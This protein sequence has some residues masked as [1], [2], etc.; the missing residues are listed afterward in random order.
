MKNLEL[1]DPQSMESNHLKYSR[2]SSI[3]I[4]AN[5]KAKHVDNDVDRSPT[6]HTN[7][8]HNACRNILH[9]RPILISKDA[10]VKIEEENVLF[11]EKTIEESL[12]GGTRSLIYGKEKIMSFSKEQFLL[13]GG[14]S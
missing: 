9:Y 1:E 3:D 10:S 5:Y 7:N 13:H 8:I 14:A 12:N 11:E 4:L 6:L 2:N